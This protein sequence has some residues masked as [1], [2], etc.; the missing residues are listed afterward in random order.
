M[1]HFIRVS[2]NTSSMKSNREMHVCRTKYNALVPQARWV[3]GKNIKR[4]REEW[5]WTARQKSDLRHPGKTHKDGGVRSV[6]F[7]FHCCGKL[8]VQKQ[9]VGGKGFNWFLLLHHSISLRDVRVEIRTRAWT[10]ELKQITEGCC[11]LAFYQSF[12]LIQPRTSV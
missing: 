12:V 8:R 7:D 11:F 1:L 5:A 9:A 4:A 6:L 3:E 10:Q 2:Q